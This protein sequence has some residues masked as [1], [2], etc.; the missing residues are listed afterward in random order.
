MKKSELKK[1]RKI[2]LVPDISWLY[3]KNNMC[4][5]LLTARGVAG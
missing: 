4:Y 3:F 1:E 2:W 5:W